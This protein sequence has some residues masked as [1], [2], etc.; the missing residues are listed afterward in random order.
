MTSPPPTSY[1]LAMSRFSRSA[2]GAAVGLIVATWLFLADLAGAAL[3]I[4]W[5]FDTTLDSFVLL[6]VAYAVA[7]VI[8]ALTGAV[9]GAFWPVAWQLPPARLA[10]RIAVFVVLTA[11]VVG[12]GFAVRRAR[13]L[14]PRPERPAVVLEHAHP[15]LLVVIDTLRADVLYGDGYTMPLAPQL[16]RLAQDSLVFADVES[17]S[18][19]TIPSMASLMTGVHCMTT[20][21]NA[22]FLPDWAPT[23]AEY[24]RAAGYATHA[25]VDNALLE[26][27][28]GFAAGF[29]SF[30]QRSGLRFV[31]SLPSFRLLPTRWREGLRE[32]LRVF[33]YG[34]G[35]VTDEALA[36]IDATTDAPLFLYVHYMDPHY[37]YYA[38]PELGGDPP[39]SEPIAFHRVMN[40]LRDDPTRVPSPGQMRLLQSRYANEIRY[41]D[42]ELGRLLDRWRARFGDD[43]AI[44]VTSDHGEEFLDH[45]GLGHGTSLHRELVWVP[46]LWRVPTDLAPQ[47]AR[48]RMI[49]DPVTQLDLVPSV[50]DMLGFDLAKL[51]TGAVGLQ[52]RSLWP[53]VRDVV[54]LPR[55]PLY[56]YNS[57]YGR[58][59]GRLREGDR[60]Y[61]QQMYYDGRSSEQLLFDLRTDPT[62]Q[63][64]LMSRAGPRDTAL[65]ARYGT[66]SQSYRQADPRLGSSTQAN[67]EALRALGYVQ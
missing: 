12:A 35:G 48:V 7:A 34:A 33:Y 54:R 14:P 55:R 31:F 46:L 60:V 32:H 5:L 66:V 10:V 21:A 36:R 64:N 2:R 19:W 27:R 40:E 52:G 3:A 38:H 30:F 62:E 37:P 39:D 15:L 44:V 4:G 9:I 45:G 59:I 49:S 67:V 28:T 63:H 51:A 65:V 41:L 56:A 58:A 6:G 20:D 53:A 16:Q 1:C 26:P 61:V 8:G 25:V 23:L 57:R 43:G 50:L 13:N 18:G 42:R 11:S 22:G 47:D 29:E 24:L 17:T